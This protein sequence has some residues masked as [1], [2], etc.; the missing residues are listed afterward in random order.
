MQEISEQLAFELTKEDIC[1][2]VTVPALW[3]ESAKQ[4]MREVAIEVSSDK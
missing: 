2:V 1:W 3:N 4:F